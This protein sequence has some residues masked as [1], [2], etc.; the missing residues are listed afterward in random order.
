MNCKKVLVKILIFILKLLRSKEYKM[1]ALKFVKNSNSVR[2]ANK[3]L[4][5]NGVSSNTKRNYSGVITIRTTTNGV[6]Q[7]KEI[8][9]DKINTAYEKSLKEYAEKL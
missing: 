7:T 8:T 9:K 2:N 1:K 4:I 3:S 5:V 6:I